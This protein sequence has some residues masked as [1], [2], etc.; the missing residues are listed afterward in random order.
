MWYWQKAFTWFN[1]GNVEWSN[2][3]LI[4]TIRR[5]CNSSSWANSRGS[6]SWLQY[7]SCIAPHNRNLCSGQ[8]FG[9]YEML[10]DMSH[11]AFSVLV[12]SPSALLYRIDKLDFRHFVL[13]DSTSE[14]I[15]QAEC[16]DLLERMQ[17]HT[18]QRDLEINQK[19]N[20]YK[21][22]IIDSVIS[23]KKSQSY[24]RSFKH[25]IHPSPLDAVSSSTSRTNEHA[26]HRHQKMP[27][28]SP[29]SRPNTVGSCSPRRKADWRKVK[30][31]LLLYLKKF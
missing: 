1:W 9:S 21:Q 10:N 4:Q 17:L 2:D 5:K 12:S 18:V 31:I 19:W 6:T 28:T 26:C 13:R 3:T 27:P 11:A 7:F 24:L 15:L 29:I 20:S 30:F 23:P 25:G 16:K 8:Y 14:Y 22:T